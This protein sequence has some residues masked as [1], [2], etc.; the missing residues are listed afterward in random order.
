MSN[1]ETLEKYVS[2]RRKELEAAEK[3]AKIVTFKEALIG[4]EYW[5]G[6]WVATGVSI[7]VQMSGLAPIVIQST[8]LMIVLRQESGGE[9]NIEPRDCSILIGLCNPI[10]AII[11][12]VSYSYFG[13]KTNILVG[14]IFCMICHFMIGI[15]MVSK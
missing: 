13:R 12:I 11:S 9:F 6:T 8:S 10:F 15:C 2:E 4:S 7:A 5:R 3:N 1:Q 14:H